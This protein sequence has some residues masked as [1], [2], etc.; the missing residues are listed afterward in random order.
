MG[1]P[2]YGT[3]DDGLYGEP[4]MSDQGSLFLQFQGDESFLCLS[5]DENEVLSSIF[6]STSKYDDVTYKEET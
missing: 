3:W 6:W 4:R 5:F 2:L 1:G